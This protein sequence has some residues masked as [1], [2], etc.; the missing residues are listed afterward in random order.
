MTAFANWAS[1]AT[2]EP[3][4]IA[5]PATEDEVRALVRDATAA[6]KRV[7][8]VGAGHSWSDAAMT[9]GVLVRLD[10]LNRLLSVDDGVATVEGGMRLCD[11]VEALAARGWAL[12]I[13]GS[14]LAQTIAGATSTGTHGS[15]LRHCSSRPASSGCGSCSRRATCSTSMAPIPGSPASRAVW[16]RAG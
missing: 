1:T 9:D 4:R 16:A 5:E 12:P 13:T 7:K 10:R 14:I 3:E 11:L 15:S 8:T 6:G 2:C